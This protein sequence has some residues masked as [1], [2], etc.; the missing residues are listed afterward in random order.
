MREGAAE[1]PAGYAVGSGGRGLEGW[2][3][4]EANT[5]DRSAN[6][7]PDLRCVPARHTPRD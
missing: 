1:P 3:E 5:P 4:R 6:Q 7:R 2:G